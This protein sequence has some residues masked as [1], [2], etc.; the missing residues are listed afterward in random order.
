[1]ELGSVR[2]VIAGVTVPTP[3]DIQPDR[4]AVATELSA[5]EVVTQVE[6]TDPSNAYDERQ[7][8]GAPTV[9]SASTP[10]GSSGNSKGSNYAERPVE[11][12]VVED[13]RTNELVYKKI[14]LQSG[15]VIQQVPEESV[16]RMRAIMQAWGEA[17]PSARTTAFD[18]TA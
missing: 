2:P 15:D 1:M 17:P 3:R 10:Q 12:T 7:Q 5:R 13:D 8:V 4:N 18:L 9:A 14:D 6:D 11:R 16:L